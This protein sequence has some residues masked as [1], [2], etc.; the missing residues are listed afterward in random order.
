MTWPRRRLLSSYFN[1]PP[2]T[3]WTIL[4]LSM[5][6][7]TRS[8]VGFSCGW[9]RQW[10]LTESRTYNRDGCRSSVGWWELQSPEYHKASVPT[11]ELACTYLRPRSLFQ[12]GKHQG[13]LQSMFGLRSSCRY[14]SL[15][16]DNYAEVITTERHAA[17]NAL[18]VSI[19]RPCCS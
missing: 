12:Q 19:T 18:S 14:D 17:V 11:R 13:T 16:A 2:Q 9:N 6:P 15:R 3:R 8:F 10:R 1:L 5:Y 4:L 7:R